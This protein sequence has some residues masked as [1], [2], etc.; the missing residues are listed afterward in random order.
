MIQ[1]MDATYSVGQTIYLVSKQQAK[2]TSGVIIEE[3]TKKTIAST[4]T[5]YVVKL[6]DGASTILRLF[7]IKDEI[8]VNVEDIRNTLIS[9][10]TTIIDEMI[11]RAVNSAVQSDKMAQEP[12]S[13]QGDGEYA[14]VYIDGQVA[15]VKIV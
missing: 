2:I 11:R 15:K 5:D 13:V 6:N 7:D 12:K 10:T 14:N 4:E 9:R 3:I 1:L 8:F